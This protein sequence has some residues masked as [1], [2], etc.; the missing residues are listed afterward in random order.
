MSLQGESAVQGFLAAVPHMV[1]GNL[2]QERWSGLQVKTRHLERWVG[3]SLREGW[4]L[5][6]DEV[7]LKQPE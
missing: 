7:S 5:G 1:E 2:L 6:A 3:P 4:A